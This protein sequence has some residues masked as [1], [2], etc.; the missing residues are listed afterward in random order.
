MMQYMQQD[1]LL[2]GCSDDDVT[3]LESLLLKGVDI[4]Q[5]GFNGWTALHHCVEKNSLAAMNLLCQRGANVHAKSDR[6]STPLHI[7]CRVGSTD[8]TDVLLRYGSDPNARDICGMTPLHYAVR[9]DEEKAGRILLILL[10]HGANIHEK[11]NVRNTALHESCLYGG[12]LAV[13]LIQHGANMHEENDD[14]ETATD[15]YTGND[16]TDRIFRLFTNESS[17]RRRKHFCMFLSSLKST[18]PA[19]VIE[20]GTI[21][22]VFVQNQGKGSHKGSCAV[23]CSLT[24]LKQNGLVLKEESNETP[25]TKVFYLRELLQAIASYL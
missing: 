17:W 13:A 20:E 11:D 15:C 2:R 14:G 18:G 8:I 12:A 6:L 22:P 21:D 25:R 10:N 23:S 16:G 4:E 5:K 24:P 19:D 7:A 1:N 3:R 9:E